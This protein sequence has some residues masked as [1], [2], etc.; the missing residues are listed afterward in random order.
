M[1]VTKIW[2]FWKYSDG[3][4]IEYWIGLIGDI[5]SRGNDKRN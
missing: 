3:A 4:L 5:L 2:S 1:K